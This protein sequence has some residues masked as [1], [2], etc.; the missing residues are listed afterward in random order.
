MTGRWKRGFHGLFG[1]YDSF[2]RTAAVAR[3]DAHAMRRGDGAS[4]WVSGVA[5]RLSA[6]V[7]LSFEEQLGEED[8]QG[9]YRE[10]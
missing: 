3:F 10:A 1:Q 9:L 8:V 7:G 2:L 6:Q 4:V 5:R